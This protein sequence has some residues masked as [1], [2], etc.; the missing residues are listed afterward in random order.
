[1]SGM[2][3][4]I[5]VPS[6][7]SPN[8]GEGHRGAISV[9]LEKP[10]GPIRPLPRLYLSTLP[11]FAARDVGAVQDSLRSLVLGVSRAATGDPLYL[12]VAC[13]LAGRRGIYAGN[14]FNRSK[15]LRAL[16]RI[17]ANLSSGPYLR[18]RSDSSFETEDGGAFRPSFILLG[19]GGVDQ[20]V[21]RL[22][23][24]QLLFR[25]ASRRL[26]VLGTEELGVLARTLEGLEAVGA[27]DPSVA[28]ATLRA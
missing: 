24:G 21:S 7:Q 6:Q 12:L 19:E 10:R 4:H 26:G 11:I 15:Y 22:R 8:G 9:V 23:D 27:N 18:L 2:L 28:L 17:G 13:E 5:G 3:E 20:E 1:M 16:T 25:I 14:V